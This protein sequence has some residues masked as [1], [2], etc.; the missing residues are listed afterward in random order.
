MQTD[1]ESYME[2]T[3]AQIIVEALKKEGVRAIFGYPG[4]AVLDIFDEF[5]KSKIPFYLTRHE[6][7]AVH[8]ADGFARASGETGVCIATSGPGGTNLVT[9][10]ATANMD[11]IPV[12]ALT[13]QVSTQLIGNDAFQ[14][15]DITGITRPITKH[16]YIV[17]KIEDLPRILKEAFFIA[18]TGR[19]G[20]VLVDIPKDIQQGKTHAPY[21]KTVQLRGYNPI[22]IGHA[23]QI[24]K[25]ANAIQNASKPVIYAGGGVISSGA[26]DEL[27]ELARRLRIPVTTT[28][29]GLGCFPENDELSLKMLGMHGTPY[30][31]KAIMEAD[32]ILA[33]GARFD[34]RITGRVDTFA[35]NA[36]IAHIDIDPTTI[37]KN[38][39]VDIPVVGDVKTVLREL[40]KYVEA[41]DHE[42]WLKKI[43]EWKQTL[44]LCYNPE[45]K[46][47]PQA[48]IEQIHKI[49]NGNAI[50]TTEVGQNQMWAAQFYQYSK[51]RTFISSGGLGTM[52]YGFPAAIGAQIAHPDKIVFDIAGDGSFQMNI[53]EMATAVTYQLPINIAIMN[54]QYLGMV[55]QWQQMFY[56][57]RYS[58]TCLSRRIECP[59][60][61][62]GEGVHCQKFIPD[63]VKIAEAYGAKG[64]R[65]TEDSQVEPALK[66]AIATK[67]LVIIEFLIEREENV[68]P[69]VPAGASLNEMIRGMA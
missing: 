5:Y 38:V 52:G 45:G 13:G 26:S 24:R 44:P 61:C 59:H 32:L 42:A 34:D 18:H 4:G 16:N 9:G 57:K 29:M 56:G 69:I 19:H 7:G 41:K 62:N 8:A 39:K 49:T 50:I 64:I 54:N 20:P 60:D 33:I 51:P 65:V 28:L 2:R 48:I 10:L 36:V 30:A 1:K 63:F 66:E 53:Q 11:S 14:E 23:N 27:A 22:L 3:G 35:P 31:N 17:Q 37:R 25:L 43:L 58:S 68:Y 55:R 6:Q 47:K 15:A 46:L 21:P 12:V 67:G 40:L